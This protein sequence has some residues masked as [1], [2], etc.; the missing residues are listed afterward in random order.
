MLE[1]LNAEVV[2]IGLAG[3]VEPYQ[4]ATGIDGAELA[5]YHGKSNGVPMLITTTDT[6]LTAE[7]LQAMFP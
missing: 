2:D 6:S 3:L 1:A 4:Q 5:L 7:T